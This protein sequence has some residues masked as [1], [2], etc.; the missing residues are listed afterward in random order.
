MPLNHPINYSPYSRYPGHY[1][2]AIK[3]K[4]KQE[5]QGLA[6]AAVQAL[7]EFLLYWGAK[8]STGMLLARSVIQ[9]ATKN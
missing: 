6:A 7:H 3:N 9:T 2:A 8:M 1:M 4:H 5:K